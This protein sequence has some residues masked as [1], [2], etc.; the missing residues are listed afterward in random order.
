[1]MGSDFIVTGDDFVKIWAMSQ[2]LARNKRTCS[3]RSSVKWKAEYQYAASLQFIQNNE[4]AL[5]IRS[6]D[7]QPCSSQLKAKVNSRQAVISNS[8]YFKSRTKWQNFRAWGP[9]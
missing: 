9:D 7:E 6:P 2:A 3:L 5:R 1:M 8:N 4:Y